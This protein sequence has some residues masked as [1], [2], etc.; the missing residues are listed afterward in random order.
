MNGRVLIPLAAAGAVGVRYAFANGVT[1]ALLVA[2]ALAPVWL[3]SV[4][5]Y[6]GLPAILTIG[7][8]G[9][10]G[11]VVL[12]ALDPGRETATRTLLVPS[13]LQLLTIL[14]SIGVLLWARA[15]VGTRL[16]AVAYGVGLLINVAVT[17]GINQ[18]NAFKFSFSIPLIIVVLALAHV[19]GRRW[20]EM[21]VI[22]LLAGIVG[23]WGDS[24]S[25][26]AVLAL[27][28]AV[29]GWQLMAR[30]ASPVARPWTTLGLLGLSAI[31]VF[32]AMQAIILEGVLGEAAQERSAAQI[33][34]S[35]SLVSGGRPELGATIA[36]LLR[37]PWGYGSG[38]IPTS[39][40]VWVA[41]SGMHQLNYDPN[42][43]YVANYM[44]ASGFEVHSVLGDLWI[45]FGV[46][47][48]VFAVLVVAYSLYGAAARVS[49]KSASALLVFLAANAAWD[50]LFTPFHTASSTLILVVAIAA[51]PATTRD[52]DP[53]SLT[54]NGGFR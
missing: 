49:T 37:Q 12:T 35:G 21:I 5:R 30:R 32:Q 13:S 11:G 33:A 2:V 10:A 14:G 40:D 38:V 25:M 8:L 31:A 16:M 4:S 34:T 20:P 18:T 51:L 53:V 15:Q 9:V 22:A 45:R 46:F 28:L 29:T 24:R 1:I 27:T 50:L 41:K 52:P 6:R 26:V 36:L 47:A 44:F 43:G 3:G 23:L 19:P 17:T 7:V 48:A 54:P 39:S 42:N